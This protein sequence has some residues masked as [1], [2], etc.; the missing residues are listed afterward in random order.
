MTLMVPAPVPY[1][2]H[3]GEGYSLGLSTEEKAAFSFVIK[4]ISTAQKGV[5]AFMLE[6]FALGF[7]Q[8]IFFFRHFFC[9]ILY[10]NRVQ[11]KYF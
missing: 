10:M 11:L 8:V 5:W 9:F 6:Q 2:E 7:C 4:S 3:P 1:K